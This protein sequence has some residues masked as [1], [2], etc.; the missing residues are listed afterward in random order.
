MNLR[1][2]CR[3]PH[4]PSVLLTT[5]NIDPLF[6]ERVILTDLV[7]GGASRIVVM[8]DAE[9]AIPAIN[10]ARGQLMALGRRYRV[11]PVRLEGAFHPKL[12]LRIGLDGALVACGSMNLTRAGWL[13]CRDGQES[14]GNREVSTAWRVTPGTNAAVAFRQFAKVLAQIPEGPGD[15][16]EIQQLLGASWLD[17]ATTEEAPTWDWRLFGKHDTLASVL[18][19]RWAGRRFQ[20]LRM[21]TGSTDQNAAMIRWAAATFGISQAIIEVDIATCDFDP[22]KLSDIGIDLRIVPY[23]GKPR[24]HMKVALFESAKGCAAVVGS[25]NC[26][27]AAWLRRDVERGN[28]EAC[29]IVDR[30]DL[31]DYGGLFR[32]VQG[33]AKSWDEVGLSTSTRD[34]EPEPSAKAYRL[35]GLKLH[36]SAGRIMA[37]LEPNPPTKSRVFAVVQSSRVPLSFLGHTGLW[38]GSLPDIE[39]EFT[40]LFG[41]VAVETGSQV[42]ATDPIWLDD[43]D[44]LSEIA[45]RHHRFDAV[46]RLS[47]TGPSADYRRLLEDLHVLAQTLLARPDE[48]PD[49]I[50]TRKKITVKES[51]EP[52]KPVTANNLIRTLDQITSAP[53]LGSGVSAY[54]GAISLTGIMRI[55]FLEDDDKADIDPTAAE[56]Q[57]S[58]E[59]LEREQ[60]PEIQEDSATEPQDEESPSE[61]QRK[62][63]IEQLDQFVDHFGSHAFATICSARQLQ[64]AAVYPLA[65]TRFATRGP[66]VIEDEDANAKLA[67]VVNRTCEILFFRSGVICDP[68]TDETRKCQPLLEEARQRYA[69]EGRSDDFDQILGD[70][71]LWLVLMISL[72]ALGDDMQATFGRNLVLRDVVRYP[73][74]STSVTPQHLAPL[75]H[76]LSNGHNGSPIKKIKNIVRQFE[77]LERYLPRIFEKRKGTGA[78]PEVDD[79]LWNP[80]VGFAQIVELREQGR[81]RVHVRKRAETLE[82]VLLSYYIN[83]R[84]IAAKDEKLQS[85]MYNCTKV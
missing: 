36:R 58:Q 38:E 29:L 57:K 59:E 32:S 60:D 67:N 2:L 26:S 44:R 82:T 9:Q 33:E 39:D 75:L 13:G 71:T 47:S 19:Q 10:H 5:Y 1:E 14:G 56:H 21:V 16:D 70:G 66:W 31:K 49:G 74:L 24:T 27:G 80:S 81:A 23:D 83:I 40:T 61:A 72:S 76:R 62:R 22:M 37:D 45:G 65:V 35:L 6:F 7:S 28:I 77:S 12:C 63:F 46:R 4:F 69:V 52:P 20:R 50:A 68:D 15:R 25:A 11:I 42:E 17:Q 34:P 51:A 54:S 85:L 84:D 30:C 8:A 78:K 73:Y 18:Q 64:Q 43:L 53:T 79:W 41:H 48:F 3:V 55:L